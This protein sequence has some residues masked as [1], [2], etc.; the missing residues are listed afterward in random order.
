MACC[1][2]AAFVL[3]QLLAPFVWARRHLFGDKQPP[4]VAVSWSL[5]GG[6][7]DAAPQPPAKPRRLQ[8]AVYFAVLVELAAAVGA[9]AYV[10]PRDDGAWVEAAAFDGAWCRSV[11]TRIEGEL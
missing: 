9:V 5:V 11:W 6:M 10:A 3:T 2:F 1:A 8:T 4:N 7:P